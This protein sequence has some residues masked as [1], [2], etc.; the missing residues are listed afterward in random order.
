MAGKRSSQAKK[1]EIE[2]RERVESRRIDQRYRTGRTAIRA[3]AAVFGIWLV[4]QSVAHLAGE[5]TNIVVDAALS[6]VGDLS[7]TISLCV[8]GVALLIA[9]RE[10]RLRHQSVEYLQTRP[11]ELEKQ[12][13]PN[14]TSSMLTPQGKTNPQDKD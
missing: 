5:R 7:V 11:K 9:W 4:G 1:A 10:R 13:D 3:V 14:R 2:S 8:A 12:H 6:V